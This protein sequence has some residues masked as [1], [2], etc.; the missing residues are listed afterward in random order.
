MMNL[1]KKVFKR[2]VFFLILLM[3]TLFF[4]VGTRPGLLA[5]LKVSQFFISGTIKLSG[6]KGQLLHG[7]EIDVF[8]C[9]KNELKIEI[10][11]LKINWSLPAI[12]IPKLLLNELS[13]DQVAI[14]QLHSLQQVKKIQLNGL[15][16][17]HLLKINLLHLDYLDQ[18]IHGQLQ[19][20]PQLPHF[21]A[22]QIHLN[23][24]T[25]DKKILKGKLHLKGELNQIK[26]RGRFH[27]L[28][29][30]TIDGNLNS[31]NKFTLM[32]EWHDLIWRK[33][34]N[35]FYSP[36]GNLKLSGLYPKIS[37]KLT[38]QVTRNQDPWI[39]TAALAGALPWQWNIDI[40]LM[41]AS[42]Y[43]HQS[44]G[45][46]ARVSAKGTIK[47]QCHGA[48]SIIMQPGY[49]STAK[50]KLDFQGGRVQVVLNPKNL[51]G[52]GS[53]IIDSNKKVD[54]DFILPK[55][56]LNQGFSLKQSFL[57]N[58]LLKI[59][60]F[61]FLEQISPE[62]NNTQGKLLVLLK[63]KGLLANPLIESKLILNRVGMGI[64]RLGL[65]L[66]PIDLVV[67][68]KE[69]KWQA[70]G[71]ITSAGKKLVIKG[72]GDFSP[73]G[74]ITIDGN[75][76]LLANSKE[77]QIKISPQLSLDISTSALAVKGSIKIPYAQIKPLI[78]S[79]SISIPEDVAIK[80]P[81]EKKDNLFNTSMDVRLEMGKEVE[82]HSK[83]LN[84]NL[85]GVVHIKQVPQGSMNASGK[86]LLQQGYYKAYGQN[87]GIEQG[88]LFFT[89]GRID[90]P[91]IS[92]KATKHINIAGSTPVSE[93]N[94]LS[95]AA[96]SGKMKVGIEVSGQ[97]S[98]PK[99]TLFSNPSLLSQ[100][101]ILS[102]LVLGRPINQA[103]K[104]GAQ[105]LLAAISSMATSNDTHS[106]KFIDS[107]KQNLGVDLN[108][109]TSSQYNLTTN[110]VSDSTG[111]VM[112]KSLSKRMY[113]S[114]NLGLSQ[115]DPDI[116]TLKY[117]LNKFL[118]IQISSSNSASGVDLL[119]TSKS[120]E[121]MQLPLASISTP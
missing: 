68:G 33:G 93:N 48:V 98:Q 115:T 108:I 54:L 35:T 95:S 19:M 51:Q 52:T 91:G 83:G 43:S 120:K 47:D 26:Y 25:K 11:H 107:L 42:L 63:A 88:L 69:K 103:N 96:L 62:I 3:S 30:F 23:P 31:L 50:A 121:R 24:N 114:Y 77:Y 49:Y 109:N 32:G 18:D 9:Q 87:L 82:L 10:H 56:D 29:D 112:G 85:S 110:Q 99:I 5:V 94:K 60:S 84:S 45:L 64:P 79:N 58:L 55:F 119:Y 7:F 6:V 81:D 36:Q 12:L 40:N 38:S 1:I 46:Y 21:F 118:S 74:T 111:I 39:I 80:A 75:D 41:R 71:S 65:N 66:Y 67:T 113:L 2:T 104:A 53:V 4:L 59:D 106:K 13:A 100:A 34:N 61:K 22:A 76:V 16:T 27:G 86:L 73:Y 90:N 89:G 72:Q 17:S 44:K 15:I 78:F 117:L 28:G 101:D 70:F 37:M 57:F 14:K 8:E 20:D 116:L 102:M 97:L 105:L 92:L